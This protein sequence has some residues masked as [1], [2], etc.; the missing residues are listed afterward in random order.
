MKTTIT[1]SLMCYIMFVASVLT[2]FAA[3]KL[4]IVGDGV[5][6]GWSIANSVVMLTE[7]NDVWKA[8]VQLKANG[9]FKF[10]T[11]PNWGYFEYR[12][13]DSNVTLSNGVTAT[14]YDSDENQND[15]KFM[16][17]ETA[18]YEI[19]CDLNQKKITVTKATYQEYPLY[20]TTLWMVGSATPGG[21]SIDAGTQLSQHADNPMVYSTTVDLKE[22][23]F[24][25]LVNKYTG[26]EQ[27]AY[28][29][30]PSDASKVVYKGQDI[31]WNITEAATY[32]IEINLATMS[33]SIVK[34][35]PTGISSTNGND[36]KKEK[37]Y[38]TLEGKRVNAPVKGIYIMRQG[39]KV[40]KVSNK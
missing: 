36:T 35:T 19:V 14:L 40:V 2:S 32:D 30:D 11:Y 7:G 23:E 24:K 4:L 31:K 33:V 22:G 5:R 16:V 18:N 29:C 9:G 37:E 27:D 1:K 20:H 28:V 17:S 10:L 38:Y 12:A 6:G 3:D 8:T 21:W 34:K 26:F 39:N 25:F 13:G 15:N